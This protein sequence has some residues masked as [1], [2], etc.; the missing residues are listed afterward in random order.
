MT[1]ASNG[2]NKSIK[3]KEC[4]SNITIKKPTNVKCI[5]LG[6]SGVGKTSL[7]V[8]YTTN[9]YPSGHN[10]SALDTFCVEVNADNRPV[11]LQI[12]DAGG[13]DEVASL[14]H[15]SYPGVHVILLCFSVV[16]PQSFRALRSAWLTEL[17]ES[18][19]V[20]NPAAARTAAFN[21]QCRQPTSSGANESQTASFKQSSS[22]HKSTQNGRSKSCGPSRTSS[23]QH[24]SSEIPGPALLLVG[25][26]CD[27][28]NDIAQLLD[29]S[30]QGE[31]PVD[32]KTAE[33]LAA[34]LGAEAYIECSALT[35]KNLKTVFDLAIW[36][37]LRVVDAGGPAYQLRMPNGTEN[38]NG[39]P[40]SNGVVGTRSPGSSRMST[41]QNSDQTGTSSSFH[42]KQQQLIGSL[43]FDQKS[44]DRSLWRKLLCI[45]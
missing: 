11:N 18:R 3:T 41:S 29:L 35:Q 10:P 45:D 1:F 44:S 19:I 36:C 42:S 34:E 40:S 15:F 30:K 6:D 20:L 39:P 26:A 21:L 2:I 38:G 14:R 13:G 43:A 32:P 31:E 25:C 17:A 28:R 37:G 4:D 16:K 5:L 9:D 23:S 12:C 8:S 27:L 33:R 24:T 22:H 7:V